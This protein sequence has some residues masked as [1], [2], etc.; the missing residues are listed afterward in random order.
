MLQITEYNISS[1]LGLQNKRG[2]FIT[3]EMVL[4][5]IITNV[6]HSLL[7]AILLKHFSKFKLTFHRSAMTNVRPTN[8]AMIS[9][10]S[11]TSKTLD[12]TELTKIFASLETW[13]KQFPN[14]LFRMSSY[15]QSTPTSRSN[16]RTPSGSGDAK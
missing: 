11:E 1:K 4:G 10:E 7:Y 2:P 3:T 15:P 12:I 16:Q 13:K 6:C 9:S 8:L 14:F 5:A